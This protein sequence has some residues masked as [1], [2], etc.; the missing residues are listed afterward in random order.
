MDRDKLVQ[1]LMATFLGELEEHLRA[2]ERDLL[3]LDKD[4]GQ[5]RTEL[6]ETLFRTAHSLKGAA[7]S[8]TIRPIEVA[9]HQLEEILSTLRDGV[10]PLT[11]DLVQIFFATTDALKDAAARLRANESLSGTPIEAIVPQL[12]LAGRGA[13]SSSTPAATARG[14]PAAPAA[15]S[16]AGLPGAGDR[17]ARVPTEKLDA[18]VARSGELLV[19]RRRVATHHEELIGLRSTLQRCRTEWQK[20]ERPVRNLTRS[21]ARNGAAPSSRGDFAPLSKRAL[22]A[23]ERTAEALRKLDRNLDSLSSRMA[24]DQHTLEQAAAPLDEDIRRIRLVPFMDACEGLARIVRDVARAGQ[25]EVELVIEGRD[26]EVDRAVLERLRDPLLHLVRN[27]VDH[28]IESPGA[29]ARAG[30]AARATV[31]VAAALRAG[32]VAITVADDGRGIDVA[33][34]REQ[35]RRRKMMAP[36]HDRDVAR[37][38]LVPGFSTARMITELSG[39]GVG[40]DVVKHRVESLHGHLD[41]SFEQGQ[42]TRFTLTV[43]LTLTTVRALLVRAGGQVY[44]LPATSVR[45][46]IRIVASDIGSIEGGEVLLSESGP[47]PLRSLAAALRV[48]NGELHRP[49]GKLCVVEVAAGNRIVA[50]AV[51]EFLAEQDVVVKTLGARLKRVT[52]FAGATVL[53]TGRLALILAPSDL[54]ESALDLPSSGS[55][56]AAAESVAPTTVK[57]LLVVDD[58]VTTRSLEKSILEAAGYEVLVAV[59]GA[60]A[61]QLLQEKGVDLVVADVE[62]PRMNGFALCEA[63]RGSKRYRDLPIVLV[64]ALASDSDRMRGL[65]AGADAYL[66]KTAFDQRQLLETIARLA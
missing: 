56:A 59:D 53:P 52:N 49:S 22:L 12:E 2:L 20:L 25:K 17:F 28:G 37:L 55:F 6:L 32:G 10:R 11:P 23:L 36:E 40:L 4:S 46:L 58:S 64:T 60:H 14:S 3:A 24:A 26:V 8:V 16:A 33:A 34:V 5:G 41:F 45:R 44:A 1:R 21:R 13:T 43:P 54:V 30:K 50:L 48:R 63:I 19:A 47:V 27:A 31:T 7:R 57:R 39:R 29:R 38:V 51:D 65:E 15:E 9:C 66:V 35:A 61:W 42:G 18:L 62:M